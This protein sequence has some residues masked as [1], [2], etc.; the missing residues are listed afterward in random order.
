M[1]YLELQTY[2]P[3]PPI[4]IAVP[5][6]MTPGAIGSGGKAAQHPAQAPLLSG[7]P[8]LVQARH[9]IWQANEDYLRQLVK[10]DTRHAQRDRK[11]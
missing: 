6:S 11:R 8:I 3:S 1:D 5:S 10:S 4:L 2:N 7:R 9:N